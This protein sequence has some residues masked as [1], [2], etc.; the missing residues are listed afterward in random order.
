MSIFTCRPKTGAIDG[1]PAFR[2]NDCPWGIP[3]PLHHS[4]II[5]YDTANRGLAASLIKTHLPAFLLSHTEGT[6]EIKEYY[7]SND[8][9]IPEDLKGLF[10]QITIGFKT[11]RKISEIQRSTLDR[12]N[13]QE[14][15]TG[16]KSHF[17]GPA[18]LSLNLDVLLQCDPQLDCF[19]PLNKIS[20]SGFAAFKAIL[21]IIGTVSRA[22]LPA[23]RFKKVSI[24]A[25]VRKPYD[26][27][28]PDGAHIVKDELLVKGS[29]E[30]VVVSGQA[31]YIHT[32]GASSTKLVLK[33]GKKIHNGGFF[34][35]YFEGLIHADPR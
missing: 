14:Y 4:G 28:K 13:F 16:D 32:D 1:G 7:I 6:V 11:T 15:G 18:S 35:R 22:L 2:N 12:I 27:T 21:G 17:S 31:M 10:P 23:R 8:K 29:P 3:A 33:P 30:V 20:L 24:A 9:E 5:G 34:F 26:A 25:S 19:L